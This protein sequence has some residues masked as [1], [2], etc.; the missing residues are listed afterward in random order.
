MHMVQI[1][2][3]RMITFQRYQ[4][5]KVTDKVVKAVQKMFF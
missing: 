2:V 1:H 3:V 4:M 5:C